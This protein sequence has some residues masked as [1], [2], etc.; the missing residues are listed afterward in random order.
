MTQRTAREQ[1]REKRQRTRDSLLRAGRDILTATPVGGLAAH[2]RSGE[3]AKRA[4]MSVG[5]LYYHWLSQDDYLLD[6]VE[7][8]LATMSEERAKHAHH[9]ACDLFTAARAGGA[10]LATATREAGNQVFADLQD[11][12]SVYV[13]LT[14]WAAHREDQEI[15]DRLKDMYE[16]VEEHWIPKLD[17][18]NERQGRRWRPPF[19]AK[20]MMTTMTALAE[21]LLLRSKVD[22]DAVPDSTH[23]GEVWSQFATTVIGLYLTMTAPVDES[24]DQPEDVRD[25]AARLG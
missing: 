2:V 23:D 15:S 6:L 10:S 18:T 21:G 24:S 9:Q 13:Q 17:E 4:N 5:S 3:V 19:D 25:V 8:V 20:A 7:Y 12:P 16:R 14:L 11:D 1:V 22:P